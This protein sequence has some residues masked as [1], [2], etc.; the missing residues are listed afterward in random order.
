MKIF[1]L[2]LAATLVVASLMGCKS[3]TAETADAPTTAES[4]GTEPE[5]VKVQHILIGFKGSLPGQNIERSADEAKKL[6]FEVFEKAKAKG[7]DF[8]A[9]VKQYSEDR[10]PGVYEMTNAGVAPAAGSFPREGMVPAFG[11]VGFKLQVGEVGIAE[12]DQKNSPFGYHII[13]RL[14]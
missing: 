8:E 11:N 7:A 2:I 6:A 10:P 4:Q 1:S 3:K 12:F 14:N 13:K 9:L 5:R